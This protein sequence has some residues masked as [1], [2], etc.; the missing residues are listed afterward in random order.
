M[1]Y[2]NAAAAAP[3]Y[4]NWIQRVGAYLIDYIIYAVP[5]FIGFAIRGA[6]EY[7]FILIALGILVYNR[8]YMMGTTGQSWGKKALNVKLVSE[9]TGEPM[10]AVMA[11]VRDI[12]HIVDAIICYVGFL[13]P[14]WDAKRQTLADKIMSTVV[15][16]V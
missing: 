10:G 7:L 11:F 6:V 12:A 13:F 5:L 14:L 8:W 2:E 1:A 16:D 3:A 4:A 15:V 9:N